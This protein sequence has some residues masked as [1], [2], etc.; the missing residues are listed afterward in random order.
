M[1]KLIRLH[2]QSPEADRT[3]KALRE[4]VWSSHGEVS[5]PSSPQ[6]WISSAITAASS[7]LIRGLA[8]D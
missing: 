7:N 5:H 8:H 3:R 6:V 1:R 4:K 2:T